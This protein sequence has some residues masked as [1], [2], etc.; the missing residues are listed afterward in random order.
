MLNISIERCTN[1]LHELVKNKSVSLVGPSPIL[2]DT[3]LGKKIDSS[4]VV[5]RMGADWPTC[6]DSWNAVTDI[7]ERNDAVAIHTLSRRDL[8][9]LSEMLDL[10]LVI[11]FFRDRDKSPAAQR[12]FRVM[13]IAEM[14]GEERIELFMFTSVLLML[15]ESEATKIYVTGMYF[16]NS[17][18]DSYTIAN[19]KDDRIEMAPHFNL[20]AALPCL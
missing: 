18:I 5:I 2:L 1:P 4:D 3:R 13:N 15:L 19:L 16:A 10:Q 12:Y 20:S 6:G 17:I 11:W 7:G 9:R 14:E 8:K